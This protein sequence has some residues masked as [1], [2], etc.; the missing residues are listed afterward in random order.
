M[1]SCIISHSKTSVLRCFFFPPILTLTASTCCPVGKK[2]RKMLNKADH[3]LCDLHCVVKK[4]K[5]LKVLH[6]LF[7]C[8]CASDL[9]KTFIKLNTTEVVLV[10]ISAALD[11]WRVGFKLLRTVQGHWDEV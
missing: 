6:L 7:L 8:M 9:H 5:N 10:S 1:T 4:S 2:I 11:F 3:A